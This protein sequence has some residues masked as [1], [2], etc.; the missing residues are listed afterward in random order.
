MLLPCLSGLTCMKG[1]FEGKS[2]N[3]GI[4]MNK[5][6]FV[7]IVFVISSGVANAAREWAF[8]GVYVKDV[9]VY[10][11]NN[12]NMVTVQIEGDVNWNTG[13]APTDVHHIVSY[14][15][16]SVSSSMQTWVSMLLFA[17]AQDLPVNLWVDMNN[18]MSGSQWDV[19]GAPA[20]LG[21]H[22]Q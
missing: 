2:R 3:S 10:N 21:L 11:Y 16:N 7:V 1:C 22:V 8:Q 13:C 4:K 18:C 19:F 17:Q 9:S 5:V 12:Y 20:G 14:R 15:N 6:V